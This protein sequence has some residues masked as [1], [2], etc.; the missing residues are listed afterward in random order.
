MSQT[1]YLRV[2]FHSLLQISTWSQMWSAQQANEHEK[3]PIGQKTNWPSGDTYLHL[4][5][6]YHCKSDT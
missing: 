6:V 3:M 2:Y 4:I 1:M 5:I